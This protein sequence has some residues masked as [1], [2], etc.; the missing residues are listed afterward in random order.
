[1]ASPPLP[2]HVLVRAIAYAHAR[3]WG[4]VIEGAASPSEMLALTLTTN[5]LFMSVTAE[6]WW[7]ARCSFLH[8]AER[9]DAAVSLLT[10]A[11]TR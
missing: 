5:H 4:A 1:M 6:E 10:L 7:S 11:Y 9:V 8:R 2:A 3:G